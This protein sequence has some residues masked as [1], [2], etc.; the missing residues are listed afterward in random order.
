MLV[1]DYSRA[2]WAIPIQKKSDVRKEI[3]KWIKE[4]ETRWSKMHKKKIR[5]QAMRSDNAGENTSKML[6]D[7]LSAK[8]IYHERTVPG[9]SQ[10]NGVAE[11]AIG[12]LTIMVRHS[13][14]HMRLPMLFWSEAFKNAAIVRNRLLNS[15]NPDNNCCDVSHCFS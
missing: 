4:I 6:S 3:Q 11:R 7:F 2:V 9:C 12:Q 10:S 1:D 8:H 5:V 13:L 14:I 15:H